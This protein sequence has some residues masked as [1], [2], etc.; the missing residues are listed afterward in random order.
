MNAHFNHSPVKK[1]FLASFTDEKSE[2]WRNQIFCAV[3]K[4]RAGAVYA[5]SKL[6]LLDFFSIMGNIIHEMFVF[7]RISLELIEFSRLSDKI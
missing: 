7:I 2:V 1:I 6:R 3:G 4:Y 5:D